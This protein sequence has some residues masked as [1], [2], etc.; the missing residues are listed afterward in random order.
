MANNTVK[1]GEA[2][3][4]DELIDPTPKGFDYMLDQGIGNP[5]Q[6]Q[7]KFGI[8]TAESKTSATTETAAALGAFMCGDCLVELSNGQSCGH[9]VV[10]SD[11]SRRTIG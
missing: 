1:P 10:S 2:F 11:G 9:I 7:V 5:Y 6:A 4:A 3:L 8:V